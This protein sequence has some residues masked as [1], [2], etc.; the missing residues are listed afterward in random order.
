MIAK[1]FVAFVQRFDVGE[2]EGTILFFG[3]DAGESEN[4]RLLAPIAGKLDRF[5]VGNI[6]QHKIWGDPA[7]TQIV[8]G[9]DG[10]KVFEEAIVEQSAEV[11][12]SQHE[13]RINVVNDDRLTQLYRQEP[14]AEEATC[15]D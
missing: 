8:T 14:L 3:E 15:L 9:G 5:T 12:R 10:E 1:L 6:R 13:Q 11:G 7:I 4:H 2:A